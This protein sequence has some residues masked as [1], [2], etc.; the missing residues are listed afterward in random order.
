MGIFAFQLALLVIREYIR[1]DNKFDGMIKANENLDWIE[2]NQEVISKW[3]KDNYKA[4]KP[5]GN[6]ATS[7]TSMSFLMVI[8][9]LVARFY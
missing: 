1:P 7:I 4:P 8:S 3:L 9:V 6:S 5:G 2:K